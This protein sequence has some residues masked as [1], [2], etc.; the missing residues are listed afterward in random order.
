MSWIEKD[1]QFTRKGIPGESGR[2]SQGTQ[3]AKYKS[4]QGTMR[5]TLWLSREFVYK[6]DP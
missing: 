6:T 5:G 3:E 4:A 2:L 1:P